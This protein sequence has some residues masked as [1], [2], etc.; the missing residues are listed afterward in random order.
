MKEQITE[1]LAVLLADQTGKEVQICLT[2][3][4]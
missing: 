3:S 1:L 4:R 2:E